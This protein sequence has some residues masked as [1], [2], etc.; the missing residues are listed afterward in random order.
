[1]TP[2]SPTDERRNALKS[3]TRSLINAVGGVLSAARILNIPQSMVSNYANPEMGNRFMPIHYVEMLEDAAGRAIVSDYLTRRMGAS[4][5]AGALEAADFTHLAQEFSELL[6][7]GLTAFEDDRLT[8]AEP[9]GDR[10]GGGRSRRRPARHPRQGGKA[11]TGAR[12]FETPAAVTVFAG[13][14]LVARPGG[15][16]AVAEAYAAFGRFCARR[17]EAPTARPVFTAALHKMAMKSGG[18]RDGE[19]ITGLALRG[20]ELTEAAP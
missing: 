15:R 8:P 20:P 4:R 5:A 14:H 12:F 7:A 19:I 16:L 6:T 18:G 2:L 1:M 17:G 10:P 9:R 3:Q 11:M 13:I